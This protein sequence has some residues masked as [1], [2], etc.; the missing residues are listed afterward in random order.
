M[1]EGQFERHQQTVGIRQFEAGAAARDVL[2]G[3][4]H[5]RRTIRRMI[6]ALRM[7]RVRCTDRRLSSSFRS[8]FM[9]S[10]IPAHG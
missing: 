6:L 8:L 3:A 2:H 5:D 4:M 10:S 7:M 9:N 1:L